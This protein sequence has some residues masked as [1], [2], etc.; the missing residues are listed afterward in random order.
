MHD[1]LLGW[2][3][4]DTHKING[5]NNYASKRFITLLRSQHN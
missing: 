3:G 2:L 5:H 1:P 4:T